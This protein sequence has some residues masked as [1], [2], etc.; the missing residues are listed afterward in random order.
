MQSPIGNAQ[1]DGGPLEAPWN[2]CSRGVTSIATGQTSL[3]D[4]RFGFRPGG[5]A[6]RSQPQ[7]EGEKAPLPVHAQGLHAGQGGQVRHHPD[8]F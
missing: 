8:I 4:P 7:L 2:Q 6:P 5:I 3:R 1:A